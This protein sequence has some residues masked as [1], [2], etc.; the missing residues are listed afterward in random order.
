M[1]ILKKIEEGDE[2][3]LAPPKALFLNPCIIM[4]IASSFIQWDPSTL[5][6]ILIFLLLSD[7]LIYSI[8]FVVLFWG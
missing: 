5:G 2:M 7:I 1:A 6:E 3:Q 4:E 8:S